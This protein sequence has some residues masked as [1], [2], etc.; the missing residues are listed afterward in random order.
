M[1]HSAPPSVRSFQ[2]RAALYGRLDAHLRQKT[3]FFGAAALTNQVLAYL[4][5]ARSGLLCSPATAN[6]LCS[7]GA[8]LEARNIRLAD[9]I[10]RRYFAGA[11]LDQQLVSV[12]QSMVEDAL[13]AARGAQRGNYTA[14]LAEMNAL[15][16][17]RLWPALFWPRSEVRG[18]ARIL[19]TVRSDLGSPIE[20]SQ[21][22]HRETIGTALIAALRRRDSHQSRVNRPDAAPCAD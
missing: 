21:Q 14:T 13:K 8:C 17:D 10:G 19:A 11:A 5:S 15:L 7:I 2:T 4:A 3:R 20:F 22:R 6:W 12:E 16:N 1:S 9:R 18:Y